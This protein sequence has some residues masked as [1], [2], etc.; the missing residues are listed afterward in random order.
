MSRIRSIAVWLQVAAAL[1]SASDAT[2]GSRAQAVSESF[3]IDV[4]RL[5][6]RNLI[7][8]ID[9]T[10]HDGASFE[11]AVSYQG[12][13]AVRHP[14]AV[15]RES[16]RDG[17]QLTIRFP[18]SRRYV[19]P[20]LGPGSA[21]QISENVDGGW[22]SKMMSGLFG[23]SIKVAGSGSGLEVWADVEV[24][25]PSGA[26]LVVRHGVGAARALDVAADLELELR[27]GRVEAARIGGNLTIETGS[28]Q[29]DVDGVDGAVELSTGSGSVDAREIRGPAASIATGS[30]G[31]TLV[32]IDSRSLSVAT[33]SGRV[34]ADGVSADRATIATGSGGVRL[35]MD[36]M[37]DG[38]FE[39]GTGSGRV[40]LEVPPSAS[41]DV[42]AETGS[43]GIDLEMGGAPLNMTHRDR[44]EVRFSVGGGEA[45]VRI[46]TGSG[47]VVIAQSTR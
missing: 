8:E 6:I 44:D 1:V 14:P 35:E 18:E 24:Q 2:G 34:D 39:I 33:G 23:E 29:I 5:E 46:S 11:V 13:D 31:V 32:R 43:G 40:V 3:T 7:G 41:L 15:V 10:T 4:A 30:G 22:F 26:S 42:H 20:R 17:E 12:K 37:G 38:S 9:V 28:G 16:G 27:S 36:R 47:G 45:K 25:V 19:Y 21:T